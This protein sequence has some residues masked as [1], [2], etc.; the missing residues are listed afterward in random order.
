MARKLSIIP[1]SRLEIRLPLPLRTQMDLHLFS[2][3]EGKVPFA[4]HQGFISSLIRGYF[5]DK[6]L[7]LAPWLGT[8]AGTAIV[9]GNPFVI[10][11]LKAR[12]G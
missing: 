3:V 5:E 2:S 11:K 1:M 8:P 7:D 4:A 6:E 10:E 12:L 9:R